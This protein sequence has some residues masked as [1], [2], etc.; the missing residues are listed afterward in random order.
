MTLSAASFTLHCEMIFEKDLSAPRTRR[1]SR[2]PHGVVQ[3]PRLPNAFEE[4]TERYAA[5]SNLATANTTRA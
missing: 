1:L 4:L 2:E 5:Y 3:C